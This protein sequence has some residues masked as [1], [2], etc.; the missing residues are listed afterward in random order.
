MVENQKVGGDVGRWCLTISR[1]MPES[2]EPDESFTPGTP[3]IFRSYKE[4]W[5]LS[6]SRESRLVIF[7]QMWYAPT[8]FQLSCHDP[9]NQACHEHV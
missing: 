8:G 3:L 7:G 9:K 5:N 2:I 4:A 1:P 6:G